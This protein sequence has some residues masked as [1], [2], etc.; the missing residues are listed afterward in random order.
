MKKYRAVGARVFLGLAL[1]LAVMPA[2]AETFKKLRSAMQNII[3]GPSTGIND[4]TDANYAQSIDLAGGDLDK[5]SFAVYASSSAGSGTGSFAVQVSPDGG[6]SWIATGDTIALSTAAT[7]TS[8]HAD[9]I[10]V[11]PGT[12]CR[13][14]LTIS[15]STTFYT[16]KAWAL[17]QVQ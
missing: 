10:K 8:A 13:L 4:N 1:A 5:V 11:S 14:V 12:K 3:V 7:A 17:P 16:L 6:T 15:G 9:D 2:G